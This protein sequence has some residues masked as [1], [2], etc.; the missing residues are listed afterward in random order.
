MIKAQTLKGFRDFLPGEA[1]KRQYVINI[2]KKVFESYGFE[3]LET[4][5]LEYED[6]LLGKYGTEGDKLMYRFTDN[7]GRKVALRYDQTV[8]LARVVAEYGDKLPTPF[9]RY[10]I[11]P[12]WRAEN[13]QKGRFREFL[14]CD[15]DTVG[16]DSPLS[17]AEVIACSIKCLESLGFKKFKVLINDRQLFV[18]MSSQAIRIIDKLK[19]IG[20]EQ[21]SHQLAEAGFPANLVEKFESSQP[22]ET[23]KT[24]LMALEDRVEFSPTLARGLDYYTGM[25]FEVEIEG[26]SVGSV[27]GGGRYD[28]LVGMFAD[29]QIPAVGVAFGFDRVIEAMDQ[30]DLFPKDLTTTKVLV[31]IFNKDLSPVAID[32]ADRLR[33]RGINSELWLDPKTKLEKQLKY[34]DQKGIPFVIIIGPEEAALNKVML[35]NLNPP[36]GG[37]TQEALTLDEAIQKL[38]S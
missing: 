1:R 32:V 26:Y 8:P 11:Q 29:K 4:P 10:Q 28:N 24:I 17:D 6:V 36:A 38:T 7:G 5:A 12:V 13:T 37:K 27:A 2:L 14:Q 3:P 16:L 19:K 35:K 25:I 21:V 23:I 34:A 30:M 20:K 18:G 22:T 15:I 9:K 31:T 33:L